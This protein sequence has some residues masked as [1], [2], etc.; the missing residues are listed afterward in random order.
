MLSWYICIALQCFMSMQKSHA[1]SAARQT[2]THL[3]PLA[4]VVDVHDRHVDVIDKQVY[5]TGYCLT[6]IHAQCF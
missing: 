4:D 2:Y 1:D 6:N 5:T 3:P